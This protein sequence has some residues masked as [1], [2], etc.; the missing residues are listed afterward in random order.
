MAA[1]SSTSAPSRWSAP[2]DQRAAERAH[3]LRARDL[4]RF[5]GHLEGADDPA[6]AVDV[7]DERDPRHHPRS[8]EHTSELQS[9]QYLVCRLL[10][11]KK[12]PQ[13]TLRTNVGAWDGVVYICIT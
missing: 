1:R 13:N 11:E 6:H 7:R 10:L 4:R 2:H 12:K 5:R 9:R 3:L 8:E